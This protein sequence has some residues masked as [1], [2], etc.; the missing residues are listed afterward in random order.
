M[1]DAPLAK[2]SERKVSV[3][4]VLAGLLLV[5]VVVFIVENSRQVTVRLIIP[6]VKAP[7]YVPILIAA[8]LGG[9]IAALL[10]YRR[11]RKTNKRR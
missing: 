5:L 11:T 6:E 2:G 1:P 8:V 10:R 3:G 9:L 4:Q 7:L